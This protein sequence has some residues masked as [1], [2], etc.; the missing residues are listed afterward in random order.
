MVVKP[1]GRSN[2]EIR[3]MGKGLQKQKIDK[4]SVVEK[5]SKTSIQL[6]KDTKE[7]VAPLNDE[8]RAKKI[9]E[10]NKDMAALSKNLNELQG[11]SLKD[12]Q[13]LNQEERAMIEQWRN[14]KEKNESLFCF[15]ST[16]KSKTINGSKDEKFELAQAGLALATGA[17]DGNF[18]FHVL[19]RAVQAS[20]F[21]GHNEDAA[22]FEAFFN[23]VTNAMNAMKPQDEIEGMLI[24]RLVAL[25]FQGM[26]YLSC[27]ANPEAT[28]EGRDNNINR[29]TKLSRLYNETLE[30]LMRYRRKGE[31]KVVVQHVNVNDGGKAVVSG[32]MI[33]GG[34]GMQ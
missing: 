22:K 6:H 4:P 15:Y 10:I 11:G 17:S 8:E 14:R 33:A 7:I 34:G 26:H 3:R 31:Q 9:S 25:H 28:T 16:S 30:T 1:K 18:G 12:G 20:P 13:P 21:I 27:A 2:K 5:K 24:S 23:S 32:S 19:S 29:S